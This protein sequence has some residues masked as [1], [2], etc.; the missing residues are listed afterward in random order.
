MKQKN[1]GVI[2]VFAIIIVAFLVLLGVSMTN[3]SNSKVNYDNY[4]INAFIDGDDFNGNVPDHVKGDIS[5]AKAIIV[6]Y[7]DYQ[8][9]GCASLNPRLNT[10]VEDSDGKLAIIYRNYIMTYHQ[11]GTAAASAAEAAA[12]QGYWKDY[13][14]MLFSNQ[15]NWEYASVDERTESFVSLF[16]TVS[17]GKGDVD[18]FKSDMGSSSVQKKLSFDQGLAEKVDAPGT[19]SLYYKGERIDFSSANTEDAFYKLIN[20]LIADDIK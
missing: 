3:K 5:T 7:A 16:E 1:Y 9:P 15:S 6:E 2:A 11:N 10:L 13:A 12:K 4:D 20:E 14:D 19:P 8:C 17:G 18:Q